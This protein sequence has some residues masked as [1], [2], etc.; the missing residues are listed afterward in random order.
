ME[1][2][3]VG[4]HGSTK[5]IC[6]K[7]IENKKFKPSKNTENFN[8]SIISGNNTYHWLGEGIYFWHNNVKRAEYWAKGVAKKQN[9]MFQVLEVPICYE[10][11]RIFDIRKKEF[12]KIIKE[13]VCKLIEEVQLDTEIDFKNL[14]RD[15]KYKFIGFACDCLYEREMPYDLIYGEFKI[16]DNGEFDDFFPEITPQICVKDDKVIEYDSIKMLY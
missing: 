16:G 9:K 7:I 15:D 11:N 2:R 13:I 1:E 4:H 6:N 14:P 3:M 5:P 8:D 10:S 12:Y